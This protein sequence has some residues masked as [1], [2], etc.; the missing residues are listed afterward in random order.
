ML[1]S[2]AVFVVGGEIIDTMNR[3]SETSLRK[4]ERDTRFSRLETAQGNVVNDN[5]RKPAIK[6]N[7]LKPTLP[8]DKGEQVFVETY[9][10]LP[11]YHRYDGH[12]IG[13]QWFAGIK[14][15]RSHIDQLSKS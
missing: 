9:K 14:Q 13:E 7:S 10:G 2:G 15:A 11:I 5:P 1:I 3:L 4:I 8:P 6:T 12:Y